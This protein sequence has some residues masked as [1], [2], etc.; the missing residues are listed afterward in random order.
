MA[1]QLLKN[2]LPAL[3]I[4]GLTGSTTTGVAAVEPVAYAPTRYAPIT[5]ATSTAP[6]A[7]AVTDAAVGASSANAAVSLDDVDV[8]IEIRGAD[9]ETRSKIE[10]ALARFEEAGLELPSLVIEWHDDRF[11]CNG[12]GGL[13]RWGGEVARV[14]LCTTE[15]FVIFHELGHAW[16][17][18]NLTDDER[19][20]FLR[21][22]DL[23]VWNDAST[24]WKE[25]G[26]EVVANTIAIGLAYRELSG[27][28]L[29]LVEEELAL[30]E[31]LTG[32][33]SPRIAD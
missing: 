17:V 8:T 12:N 26:C 5:Q 29:T 3:V 22:A 23:A 11:G 28:D 30:Y 6:N 27:F 1:P 2:L 10:K 19:Q 7:T 31:T 13:F 4:I 18:T 25:R 20:E 15:T 9:E 33:P 24:P 14:E 32:H 21:A 16:D